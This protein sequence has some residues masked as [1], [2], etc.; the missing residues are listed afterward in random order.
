MQMILEGIVP[1]NEPELISYL[2]N[3]KY[4][5]YHSSCVFFI[6]NHIYLSIYLSILTSYT[7]IYIQ[8][9]TYD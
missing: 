7:F 1:T 3:F 5:S 8:T 6:T 2:I 4:I 9:P